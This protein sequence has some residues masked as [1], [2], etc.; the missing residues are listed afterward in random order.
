M[1]FLHQSIEGKNTKKDSED[2]VN[3]IKEDKIV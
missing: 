2:I 1:L 3:Q